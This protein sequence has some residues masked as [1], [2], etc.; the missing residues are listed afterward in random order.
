LKKNYL[1]Y[2]KILIAVDGILSY[3][4]FQRAKILDKMLK[5]CVYR[6]R[7][8]KEVTSK[9]KEM[10]AEEEL[11]G[12]II[13]ELISE[14]VLNEERYV[15]SFVRGKFRISKW[16]RNKIKTELGKN[17]I[18]S[19][20]INYGMEEIDETEYMDVLRHLLEDKVRF[21]KAKNLYEKK[22]KLRQFAYGRGYEPDLTD[23]VLVEINLK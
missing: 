18:P 11:S 3:G 6:D 5:Y 7:C 22:N 12:E 10:G 14:G 13:T 2:K 4:D 21:I 16:G 1:F 9:L 15:R 17:N 23:S 19:Q 20:L 8:H